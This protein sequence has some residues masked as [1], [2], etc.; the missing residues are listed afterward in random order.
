MSIDFIDF[1]R[2]QEILIDGYPN[3]NRIKR[4]HT[5]GHARG[6]R[7]GAVFFNGNDFG[8][9]QNWELQQEPVYWHRGKI[10]DSETSDPIVTQCIR[11]YRIENRSPEELRRNIARMQEYLN[12]CTPLYGLHPY[13]ENKG[14]TLNGCSG[15]KTD[16][17]F[18][19]VPAYRNKRVVSLQTIAPDGDKKFRNGCPIEGAYFQIGKDNAPATVFCEGLA[20]GLTIFN[21]IPAC[22][23]IVCF[24]CGGLVKVASE[25]PK[26]FRGVA[27]VC[28]DND[29]RTKQ[30]IGRN[31]GIDAG[32]EASAILGCG[33][34][35]PEDI[36]GSD[37]DDAR[38]EWM[39]GNW[40]VAKARNEANAR[41][42]RLISSKLK[43]TRPRG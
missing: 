26:A 20:T 43:M 13:L 35:Y 22:R 40:D 30:K 3:A 1:C 6:K 32:I 18:L 27:V 9:A 8:W 21:A 37:W 12:G 14:L 24:S 4:Y 31:P 5:R 29:H 2:F 16:G 17:Y 41:I 23:V 15:L 7:N 42:R 19:V 33:L 11:K 39:R 25:M 38:Q 10:Y 28:A 34:A 36:E